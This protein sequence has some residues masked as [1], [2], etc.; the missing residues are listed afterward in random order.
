MGTEVDGGRRGEG[1]GGGLGVR[2][3]SGWEY[4]RGLVIGPWCVPWPR[5]L[6]AKPWYTHKTPLF[7]FV[8]PRY[9]A[10]IKYTAEVSTF[11]RTNSSFSLKT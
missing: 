8:N 4:S 11:I 7:T 1:G 3:S 9:A 6:Y 2:I 10:R 5:M